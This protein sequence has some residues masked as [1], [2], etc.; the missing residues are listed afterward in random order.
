MHCVYNVSLLHSKTKM[1]E[2]TQRKSMSTQYKL[3]RQ[4]YKQNSRAQ[5]NGIDKTQM[6]SSMF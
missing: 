1:Y 5:G 3:A 2:S 6:T 4:F